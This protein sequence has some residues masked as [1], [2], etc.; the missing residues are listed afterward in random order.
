MR[1][2]GTSETLKIRGLD[3][4]VR[5]WGPRDAPLVFCLHGWMD[6][7]PTFQFM[8]EAL[9]HPW[10]IVAPDWRGYGGS[11]WLNRP[12][13]FPDYYA[14]LD[15]LVRHY[16]PDAPARLVGHSMGGNIA[17]VYA[18]IRPERVERL[19]IL[20][21]LGLVQDPAVDAPAQLAK[22]MDGIDHPPHLRTYPDHD[23]LA[24]RLQSGNPRLP[25]D[26]AGFLARALSQPTPDGGVKMAF[27]PWHRQASPHLYRIEDVMAMWSRIVAP[28]LIVVADDGFIH[29]RFHDDQAEYQRRLASFRTARV[30][31]LEDAGHNLQHDCP[32]RLAG[33]LEAFLLD[34]SPT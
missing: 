5:H 33:L 21:F 23:A 28:V 20:D 31:T 18:A 22:W 16:S 30:H 25:A 24:R 6:A 34:Q 8:V 14:D 7:S 4:H 13:W 32:E 27:D 11:E 2:T 12:Y 15:A 19:A 1:D 26:K 9:Q 3:Y 29:E 10:H 17:S